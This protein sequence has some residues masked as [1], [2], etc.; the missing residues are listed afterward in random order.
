[1]IF[2][3]TK[4]QEVLFTSDWWSRTL[5]DEPKLIAWL[6]K[7][8]QTEIGGY[9]DYMEFIR[10]FEPEERT[11]R[12]FTNIAL[13]EQKHSGIIIGVLHERGRSISKIQMP[14]TYW[15]SMNEHITDLQTAAAVNYFGEALAAFR[16]EVILDHPE[17]PADLKEM[18]SIILPD[19]QFHRETLMRL[20]GN[21]KLEEFALHHHAAVA[22]LKGIK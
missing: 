5:K 18:L 6:Q 11:H 3:R 22:A 10:R 7:L 1:M 2:T 13:D 19:E 20:A 9:D 21:D 14:S 8:Q 4:D 16:F 12:I 17:T 15:S